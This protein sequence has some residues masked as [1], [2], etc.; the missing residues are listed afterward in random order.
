MKY[1]QMKNTII[2]SA[3]FLPVR[4][5]GGTTTELFIFPET[6]EYTKR[7]F[8]FRLSTAT[9]ETRKSE[10][11]SLSGISRKIMVLGGNITLT[12]D[13]H[14]TRQLSKFETDEFEGDWKTTSTG[15]CTDFNLMTDRKTNG[16]L[17]A[18]VVQKKQFVNYIIKNNPG[19]FF[20]Y[21]FMGEVS[22]EI[23]NKRI[24]IKKGDLFVSEKPVVTNLEIYGVQN[25]ELVISE[26]V[27][28]T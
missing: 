12:H 16:M 10:F 4:W 13:N 3:S 27:F 24:N 8:R 9:V 23:E 15:K 20:I 2:P 26:I 19:W 14:Y 1:K 17:S 25:C 5:S 7:N 18:V 6:A 28:I 22:F 21:V 11:T